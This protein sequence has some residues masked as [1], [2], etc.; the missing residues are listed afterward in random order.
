MENSGDQKRQDANDSGGADRRADSADSGLRETQSG[1]PET[2]DSAAGANYRLRETALESKE[3]NLIR[4]VLILSGATV[5]LVLVLV[6]WMMNAFS[7][8]PKDVAEKLDTLDDKLSRIEQRH[9]LFVEEFYRV[10]K[11]ED[12]ENGK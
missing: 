10:R 1:V 4:L 12:K 3:Q 11:I 7:I 2:F 9:H 8:K 5:I 6:I